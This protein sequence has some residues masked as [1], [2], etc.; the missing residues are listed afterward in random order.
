MNIM[1][2]IS[3]ATA[4]C[5]IFTA[6]DASTSNSEGNSEV[7]ESN[8]KTIPLKTVTENLS[9]ELNELKNNTDMNIDWSNAVIGCPLQGISECYALKL[10]FDY[11]AHPEK[12]L[13]VEEQ[14]E[15]FESYCKSYLGEYNSEFACF[16]TIKRGLGGDNYTIDGIEDV[17][18]TDFPKI[19]E[20]KD[21]ILNGEIEP[22]WYLYVD[23]KKQM[24]LWWC[25][26]SMI[27]PHWFNKGKTLQ[28][29]DRYFKASSTLPTDI[30][31]PVAVYPNDGSHS[32]V[33]YHLLSGDVSIGEAV[34]W[35]TNEYTKSL[36]VFPD[37]NIPKPAVRQ[38]EVYQITADTYAY[39]FFFTFTMGGIPCD[40]TGERVLIG[41]NENYYSPV[42]TGGQALMINKNE[43]DMAYDIAPSMYVTEG[44]PITEIISL[45]EAADILDKSVSESVLYKAKTAELVMTGNRTEDNPDPL[46]MPT[47]KITL[48][49][50]NDAFLYDF[51]IDAVNGEVGY[52]KYKS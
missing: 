51:Y 1:K 16:K 6:C 15:Q 21:K 50:D 14:L 13:T 3:L 19:N 31:E 10:T 40:Y 12:V 37:E 48:Q 41:N 29:L 27:Y 2:T 25:A 44:E 22:I 43:I 28:M 5:L 52:L 4:V 20:Y 35:F 49:N 46:L 8:D 18:F 33:T 7:I 32:N 38:I 23:H 11:E 45:C 34:D 47:W 36:G 24:Y 17:V 30:G 39:V 26:G 9:A 42:S